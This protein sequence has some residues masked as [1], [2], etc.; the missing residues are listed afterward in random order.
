MAAPEHENLMAVLNRDVMTGIFCLVPHADIPAASLTCKWWAAL[1][2]SPPVGEAVAKTYPGYDAQVWAALPKTASLS[3]DL[4]RMTKRLVARAR[5]HL[6]ESIVYYGNPTNIMA[7][8][9]LDILATSI[10]VQTCVKT[11]VTVQA[12][13][14]DDDSYRD[15]EFSSIVYGI[16]HVVYP[17]IK[18]DCPNCLKQHPII[19]LCIKSGFFDPIVLLG[20]DSQHRWAYTPRMRYRFDGNNHS[21]EDDYRVSLCAFASMLK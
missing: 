8:V 17:M 18:N 10:R 15:A 7:T 13:N 11:I 12:V 16:K 3:V 2:K 20:P 19:E 9:K 6:I 14:L 4:R 21:Y 1:L 5:S